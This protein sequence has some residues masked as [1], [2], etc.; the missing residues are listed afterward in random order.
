GLKTGSLLAGLPLL[1][2]WQTGLDPPAG[3]PESVLCK[4]LW[5]TCTEPRAMIWPP[6]S[7][8]ALMTRLQGSRCC[9]PCVWNA[10]GDAE[11]LPVKFLFPR[12]AL[13]LGCVGG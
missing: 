12:Y 2:Q 11:P 8:T 10:R 4:A 13:V 3:S 9:S 7:L 6:L 1:Q 5:T